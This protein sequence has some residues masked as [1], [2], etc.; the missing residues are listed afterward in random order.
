LRPPSS[1]RQVL[2]FRDFRRFT[3]GDLKVWDYFNHVLSSPGHSARVLFSDDSDWGASNPWRDAREYVVPPGE[4]PAAD[5]LFLSGVDWRQIEY[6]RRVESPIPIIN[7]VQHVK[8]ACENDPLERYRF[9]PHKAIRICVAPEVTRAIER[10]GSVRGPIFTI[11]DAIDFEAVAR[12]A[13]PAKRDIDLLV[14][15]NKQPERGAAVRARLERPDRRIDVV[16]TR[17]PRAELLD[18]VGR[19]VVTVLMPNPKEGF[20]LPAVEA[21]ALGTVVVCPDCIGNRSFCIDGSNCF[22]PPYEEEAIAAA[23]EEALRRR[24]DLATMVEDGLRTARKHDLAD[25]RR[26][27]LEILERVDE[28]WAAA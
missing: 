13:S 17:I 9:L 16:D 11:P 15:A 23:A 25:E 24:D 18:L 22:R 1:K 14:V 3:G 7:L 27:F 19:A 28:L 20:Y 10:T 12:H 5:V 4:E 2:F 26:A 8:H 6:P 21:M